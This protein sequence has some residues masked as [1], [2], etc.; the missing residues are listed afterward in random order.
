MD[1]CCAQ[2][3]YKFKDLDKAFL[4]DRTTAQHD[5]SGGSDHG[6]VSVPLNWPY[7]LCSKTCIRKFLTRL[8]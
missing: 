1:D 6:T 5:I 2:C 3:G 8:S 7:A 4:L